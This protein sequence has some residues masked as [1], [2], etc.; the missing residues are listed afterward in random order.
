VSIES[1]VI[2]AQSYINEV[3][4][5]SEGL[6]E[7]HPQWESFFVALLGNVTTS[8]VDWAKSS[9]LPEMSSLVGSVSSG[10]YSVI[11]TIFNILIGVVV[12]CYVLYNKELFGAYVKKAIYSLLSVKRAGKLLKTM[13]FTDKALMGFISGKILDSLIIAINLLHRLQHTEY[14]VCAS[15]ERES[16]ESQTSYRFS[17]LLSGPFRRR[18]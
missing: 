6:L 2:N 12:S 5:W 15:C 9:V 4:S 8:I 14:A 7:N 3:I 18:L 16:S 1:L 11:R 10:V 13:D 17:G